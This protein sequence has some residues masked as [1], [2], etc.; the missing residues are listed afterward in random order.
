LP[1]AARVE[2]AAWPRISLV[3]PVFNS[4]QYL[5]QT[6]RSVVDQGY[7]NLEYFI[8][9]GGSTDGTLDVI[10][11]YEN[12]IA[13]WVSERDRGMYDALNKGFARSTS[14]V[15]GW[16][17]ATDVL[18]TR[19]LFV[20]GSVFKT[21]P[22]VEWITG[23]P[24]VIDEVGMTVEVQLLPHWSR[25]RVLLGAN[26]HIQQESTYWRR[27]LWEKA[28]GR[29]EDSLRNG[30]DFELWLR[31]FRYAKL[32]SVE[33]LIGAFRMHGD[34]LAWANIAAYNKVIDDAIEAELSSV[35][36]GEWIRAFR[37]LG[38]VMM[39]YPRPA[40]IW[41]NIVLDALYRRPGPDWT[42][43]IAFNHQS[44]WVMKK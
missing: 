2:K 31:F 23:I 20:A 36:R 35:P 25:T 40:R 10:R 3:T 13:G 14:D 28:G 12:R 1:D 9:D 11:K 44:G 38:D 4:V 8:I 42:P 15:M 17:S 34:S 33:G 39:R 5:E 7:P 18:Q 32:Y 29:A 6:I 37:R 21:F 16:I 24:T 30:G 43:T 26:R 22:E 27:S 19:G 41:K